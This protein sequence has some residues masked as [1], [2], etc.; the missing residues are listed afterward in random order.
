MVATGGADIG[1]KRSTAGDAGGI[2]MAEKVRFEKLRRALVEQRQ[3]GRI[4][5]EDRIAGGVNDHDR[6]RR[7]LEQQPIARFG[8]PQPDII[9]LHRL[10]RVDQ[11]LLHRRKRPQIA[12]NHHKAV[13]APDIDR[14]IKHRNILAARRGMID[15]TPAG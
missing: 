11:P 1:Q 12:A 2:E 7:D 5:V 13:L 8:V 9:P 3:R 14:R 10:L 6:L 4:G 15:L